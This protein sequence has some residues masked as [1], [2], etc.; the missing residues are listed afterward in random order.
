LSV[1]EMCLTVLR[2]A[3]PR[4][5]RQVESIHPAQR[6]VRHAGDRARQLAV[7]RSMTWRSR[8]RGLARQETASSNR[9]SPENR[10]KC[11]AAAP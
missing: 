7:P 6:G 11:Q 8:A 3:P 4:P 10:L 5:A 2:H 1:Q 9:R